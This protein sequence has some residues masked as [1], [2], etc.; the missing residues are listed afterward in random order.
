MARRSEGQW[1]VPDRSPTSPVFPPPPNLRQPTAR[2]PPPPSRPQ[3]AITAVAHVMENLFVTSRSAGDLTVTPATVICRDGPPH[4]HL[5]GGRTNVTC[6]TTSD[7]VTGRHVTLTVTSRH[8]GRYGFTW[9]TS[10]SLRHPTRKERYF[11]LHL[12]YCFAQFNP[13]DEMKRN[14]S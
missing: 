8:I 13:S 1:S 2:T 14:R 6:H 4:L 12:R 5:A 3:S 7:R 9:D 11:Q 10:C